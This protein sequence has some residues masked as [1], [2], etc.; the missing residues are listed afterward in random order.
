MLDV[1]SNYPT[2]DGDLFSPDALRDP[3]EHYRRIRDLGPVVWLKDVN[4]FCLGRFRD[5][6]QALR[7]ST[8]LI[9]GQGTGFNDVFN[10]VGSAAESDLL[11]R[12]AAPQNPRAPD[13]ADDARRLAATSQH[14]EIADYRADP[15]DGRRAGV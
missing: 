6:Q 15:Q 11:G 2:Y 5:V 10:A 13:P 8:V 1:A 12:R 3:I 9:S 7:A 4:V 14:A